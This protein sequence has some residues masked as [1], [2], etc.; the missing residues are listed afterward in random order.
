MY[1]RLIVLFLLFVSVFVKADEPL[2]GFVSVEPFELRLEAIVKISPF[3]EAWRLDA[4]VITE[5]ERQP[6]LDNIATLIESGVNLSSPETAISFTGRSLRFIVPDPEKGYAPDD[7]TRIP[8]AE[9]LVGVTLSS[10][11]AGVMELH[12]EWLWFAPGQEQLVLEIAS[13]GKPSARL[14]TPVESEFSWK[15]DGELGM[16]EMLPVPGVQRFQRQPVRF[17]VF[18]GLLLLTVASIIVIREKQKAPSWIGWLTM[19]GIASCVAAFQVRIDRIEQLSEEETEEL[20]YASLRNVYH[21][22][23][24]REESAI[25][26]TLDQ[27]VS[28]PL[29]EEVYLEIRQSLELESLGGPRVKVYEIALR[30]WKPQTGEAQ[31]EDL[32]V[33]AN[34]ATIGEVTHWGHTHERTNVYE[35]KITFS[36]MAAG[37]KVTDLDLLNEERVQKVSRRVAEPLKATPEVEL[38]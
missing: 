26:D 4:E 34:W 29:L 6:I 30:G 15:Q 1:Q 27:T 31:G 9:A 19:F 33:V 10:D 24:F 17:L 5:A 28:G 14:L 3:K 38:P 22:F 35:A 11:A 13:R 32:R 18:V 20:I 25:Y 21:A 36:P 7:R 37:W 8:L 23:D 2:Q 12:G 16:P